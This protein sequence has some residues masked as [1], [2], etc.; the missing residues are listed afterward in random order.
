ME[1]LGS[2]LHLL[3]TLLFVGLAAPQ[4]DAKQGEVL[5]RIETAFGNID[6]AVDIARAPITASNF[7]KYI[8]GGLY[9]GGR[10]HRAT[11]ADNYAPNLPN[12]PLLEIIQGDINP[13]RAGERF[14]PIPLE[15]TSVTGLT[16][17]VGTVSMP[18]GDEADS[19]RS[20]FVI[21]LNDQ[22]SL[23]LGGMRFDDG[24]G[25]AAFGRVVAGMDVVRTIRQQPVKGQALAPPVELKKVYRLRPA[26]SPQDH[27]IVAFET[28]KGTIEIA[29]D[30]VR[31]PI[32][33][34]NFLKYVDGRF[35]DGGVVN[36]AVRADNTVRHDVM[37][38]VIQF[39]I[40]PARRRE[41][42]PPIPLERTSATGLS[43]ADGAVSMARGGADT[44]TASFSIVIGD[45]PEMDFGGK[46]N[47]DGQGFAVFGRVVRGMNVVKAIQASP[48]G[49]SGAY[50]T[51]TLDPPIR[52]L[53][54]Y[55]P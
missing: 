20:G 13:A 15:R 53:K 21:H 35:Y 25:T 39:Q 10:F 52:I 4:S 50:R 37:I 38:Q 36:R 44:A 17:V 24:Q 30:A 34:T 6:L 12:R 32:T 9:D 16:H 1:S 55:R 27:P 28:E 29:V 23:N 2:V 19:A 18:R 49:R 45:Q 42:L 46:R 43:H 5:V 41:Q 7:L 26:A 31:A 3:V 14:P 40:D 22:P 8:D 54:A 51:E 48:T 11:R 33:A 47:A